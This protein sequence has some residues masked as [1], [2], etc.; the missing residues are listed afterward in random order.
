MFE[1]VDGREEVVELKRQ[2]DEFRKVVTMR[3]EERDK[4]RKAKDELR[5]AAR[6]LEYEWDEVW[7]ET[8][9]TGTERDGPEH[10]VL[11]LMKEMRTVESGRDEAIAESQTCYWVLSE[12]I[13]QVE[14]T[15]DLINDMVEQVRISDDM[16]TML[17][18]MIKCIRFV[19]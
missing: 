9:A 12:L 5:T 11:E 1:P 19:G 17:S 7:M 15:K 6:T 3:T 14:D 2:F 4:A 8:N 10:D 18:D 16:W 13:Q